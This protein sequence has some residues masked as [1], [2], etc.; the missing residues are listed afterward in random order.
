[1][2]ASIPL[3]SRDLEG[4]KRIALRARQVTQMCEAV[5]IRQLEMVQEKGGLPEGIKFN[6]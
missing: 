2:H 4:P 5:G 6:F 1:M 3:E